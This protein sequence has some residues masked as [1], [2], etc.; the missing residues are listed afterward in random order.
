VDHVLRC[1]ELAL[2]APT[3]SNSQNWE[4]VVVKDRAI[5]E[6][7]ARLNRRAV[8][9]YGG[10][11]KRVNRGN[12]AMEKILAAVDWQS[13]H[14]EETPVAGGCLPARQPR[15]VRAAAADGSVVALRLDLSEASRTCSW[16]RG[17]WGWVRP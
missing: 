5:K 14:F 9:V 1:I 11:G 17:P 3:G 6:R 10:I 15:A 13:D 7:F 12:E 2:K 16:R 4:F 8:A